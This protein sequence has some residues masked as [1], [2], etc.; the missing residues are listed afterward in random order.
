MYPNGLSLKIIKKF[1]EKG[2][3]SESIYD[4]ENKLHIERKFDCGALVEE[5]KEELKQ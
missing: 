2:L 4:D 3:L 1:N 5:T